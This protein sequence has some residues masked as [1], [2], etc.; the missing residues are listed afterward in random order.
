MHTQTQTLHTK[1]LC[2]D[3]QQRLG[4]DPVKGEEDIKEHLFYKSINWN[5]RSL[6][7]SRYKLQDVSAV[8]VARWCV[9]KE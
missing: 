7:P 9:E 1:F 4:C 8:V 3:P 2:R 5:R 6:L